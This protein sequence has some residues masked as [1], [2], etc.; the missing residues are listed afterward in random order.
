MVA[1][2]IAHIYS[3]Q[4]CIITN[5]LISVAVVQYYVGGVTCRMAFNTG[6]PLTVV[7]TS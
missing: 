2:T 6:V 5:F 3:T 1:M 7:S 4:I